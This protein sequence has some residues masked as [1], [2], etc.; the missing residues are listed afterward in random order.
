MGWTL[1]PSLQRAL[2]VIMA[3]SGTTEF[4]PFVRQEGMPTLKVKWIAQTVRRGL[5]WLMM[6]SCGSFMHMLTSA[7]PVLP[8]EPLTKSQQ[9]V[10]QNASQE[11]ILPRQEVCSATLVYLAWQHTQEQSYVARAIPGFS[12]QVTGR[13]ARSA[14]PDTTATRVSSAT[15]A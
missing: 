10:A 11:S 4:A 6:A 12:H 9:R 7:L 14:K 5:I 15:S 1:A 8:A 13:C 2:F 3:P